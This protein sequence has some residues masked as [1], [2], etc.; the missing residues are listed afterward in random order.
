MWM[1]P[2]YLHVNQKSD[3]DY[4]DVAQVVKSWKGKYLWCR[5]QNSMPLLWIN[6]QRCMKQAEIN[7]RLSEHQKGAKNVPQVYTRSERTC[8]NKSAVTD[9][10]EADHVIC[11]EGANI[12]GRENN[13][14]L[15]Q[16]KAAIR[17]K[18]SPHTMSRDSGHSTWATSTG[19]CLPLGTILV[20][21]SPVTSQGQGNSL[22]MVL[23]RTETVTVSENSFLIWSEEFFWLNNFS[24]YCSGP[25]KGE[26]RVER[27]EIM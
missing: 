5:V 11:W 20:I 10:T 15:R 27:A 7:N 1:L 21:S 14:R 19:L 4:D 3:Y 16:V 13:Q 8:C 17:I 9:I 24:L 22:M 6:I 23:V 25:T 26:Y 12:I 18:Q 2:L